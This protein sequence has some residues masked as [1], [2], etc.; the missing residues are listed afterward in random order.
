M[1][2]LVIGSGGREHA[3]VWGLSRAPSLA[4]P[5]AALFCTPGNA[6]IARD[7]T[8]IALPVSEHATIVDFCQRERIDLV[9]IGPE[10]PLVAGLGD[11]LDAAG[12]SVFGPSAAAARL[13]A[14]KG[15]TKDLCAAHG[16][17]TAAYRRFRAGDIVG[18]KAYVAAVGA[19]IVIKA[20]GLAAG[21]GVCVAETFEAAETFIDAC[22]GGA[23]GDAGAELVVEERLVG[24][25]A[26]FFVLSDGE[27]VVPL[28]TA[29]DHKRAFDG[30]TGPNTGGM[31]AFSPA[32]AMDRAT[33]AETMTRIVEPTIAALKA[34]GTPFKGVLYAG[35]MITP[36]GPK[37]IEYNVRFGDPE[38]Q[39][40]VPRLDGDLAA[41]LK[42][43][44]DGR[45]IDFQPRLRPE[46]A[47]SVVLAAQ[48]Y[49]G[50]YETG[51][52]ISGVEA[53]Q[54]SGEALVFH[55][56][57]RRTA[58]GDLIASG[59]RALAVTALGPDLQTAQARAYAAVARITWPQ[60]RWR[61][62]IA[63]RALDFVAA[64]NMRT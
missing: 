40:I 61:R 60:G 20:D 46:A 23:F 6:G 12:V 43:V 13:E 47:V 2:V 53:L 59:G 41:L 29:Q 27:T 57:T 58:S 54:A 26:S 48:G 51:S 15:F 19:P 14:S 45:L 36:E 32:V 34:A 31:G 9:V 33:I 35:L 7:A 50:A 37:L 44:A 18:A 3:L 22:A 62:D 56:A 11:A 39:A 21:K 49:P 64:G 38:A 30:D 5:E 25:E 4:T 55:A 10:A 8:C 42:A 28:A 63:Q 17:P 52:R 16:V 1:R 24:E